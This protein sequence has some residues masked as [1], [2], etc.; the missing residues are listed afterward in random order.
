MKITKNE[1]VQRICHNLQSHFTKIR[2]LIEYTIFE[3]LVELKQSIR[4]EYVVNNV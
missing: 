1:L 4:H 3:S 2:T